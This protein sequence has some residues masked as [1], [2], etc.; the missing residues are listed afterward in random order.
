[1]MSLT[2]ASF[3]YVRAVLR[4]RSG[5]Q[6][7]D[8]KAY[9]VEARLLALALRHEFHTV[10]ELVLRLRASPNPDLVRQV[11]DAMTIK[12]TSFFR[13]AQ[14][15]DDLRDVVVPELIRRRAQER[16]L[17]VWSGACSTGQEPYSLALLL[18]QHFADLDGWTVRVLASDLS[19]V[20]LERARRGWYSDLEVNRGVPPEL[21][22]RFFRQVDGGWQVSDEVRHRVEFLVF[23]LVEPWPAL[24][25]FDLVL[26][27]NVLI[28]FDV[29]TRQQVL[30]RARGVL[31]ADGYLMLG[32]AETTHN[33]DDGF[34]MVVR[35]GT[36][37][38]RPR[39]RPPIVGEVI[40]RV[41]V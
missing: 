15:F 35:G 32:G 9:L 2:A 11:V 3:E 28:Y 21:L 40:F 6:L 19:P 41:G 14:P 37:V 31:R 7:G 1:M 24:P 12:E 33:V 4:E 27:R 8:D 39:V 36:T 23:N 25:P 16:R 18:R 5:N 38:F 13:D 17:F 29:P 22:A 20:A 30:A 10:E 26:L 34:E